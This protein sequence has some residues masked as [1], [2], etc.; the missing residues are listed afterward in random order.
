MK[1]QQDV[2]WFNCTLEKISF[3]IDVE[4]RQGQRPDQDESNLHPRDFHGTSGHKSRCQGSS[5]TE[6]ERS[7]SG[8][9]ASALH[10]SASQK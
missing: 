5:Y 10:L 3:I 6:T 2:F 4:H 7:N 1:S 8:I 9:S